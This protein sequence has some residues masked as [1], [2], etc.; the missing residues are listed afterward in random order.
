[1]TP[2]VRKLSRG[3]GEAGDVGCSAMLG[4]RIISAAPLTATSLAWL[5]APEPQN[6]DALSQLQI[7]PHAAAV[8]G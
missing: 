1:M 3:D 7:R 8:V 6:A 4:D 2:N 5:I